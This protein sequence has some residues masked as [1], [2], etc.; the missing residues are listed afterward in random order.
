[1]KDMLNFNFFLLST[2]S[3]L[4]AKLQLL[5]LTHLPLIASAML[6]RPLLPPRFDI[7]G[8]SPGVLSP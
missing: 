3:L 6:Y 1:M 8:D 4:P 5:T 7:H 2:L